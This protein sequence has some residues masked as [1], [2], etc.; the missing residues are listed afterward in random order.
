MEGVSTEKLEQG[1]VSQKETWK[2]LST[3]RKEVEEQDLARCTKSQPVQQ[4]L[5]HGAGMRLA[6][7]G[8]DRDELGTNSIQIH[9]LFSD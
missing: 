9:R 7:L 4:V 2:G 5:W 8:Q 1:P 6:K 3:L